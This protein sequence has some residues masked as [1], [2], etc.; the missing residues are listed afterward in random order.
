[1]GLRKPH[2]PS[3]YPSFLLYFLDQ[4]HVTVT[5]VT[6][7]ILLYTRSPHVL[8]FS[9]GALG[10]SLTAKTIKPLIGESR[11]PP[12]PP[13]S[14]RSSPVRPKRTYGM[15]STH[16]TALTFYSIYL[17]F[18]PSFS[19]SLSQLV[20]SPIPR[21]AVQ[22]GIQVFCIAGIWSRVQL[23]YHTLLQVFAG[24]LLG[25]LLALAWTTIWESRRSHGLE[26]ALQASIDYLWSL[27]G[28]RL[29][30]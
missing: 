1:M 27:T 20:P 11:P 5:A 23:G 3:E 26:Y 13:A 7:S 8:W 18:N 4:T 15:P 6:A 10:S 17:L 25:T 12:P 30:G 2:K 16:S 22:S 14:S 29:F 24:V 21:F 9:I 28:Q 19:S